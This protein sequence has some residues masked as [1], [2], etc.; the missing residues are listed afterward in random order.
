MNPAAP[1]YGYRRGRH[2]SELAQD[3]RDDAWGKPRSLVVDPSFDWAGDA[4]PRIPWSRTVIYETH[5]KGFTARHPDVPPELRGTYL[6]FAQP[7]VIDYL[8]RLGVTAVEFLPL[9]AFIDDDFLQR[10]GLRNYWGYNSLGFFAPEGRYSS[11][12][13]G[14][15]QVCEFKELVKALHRAGI[16]VIL[17]VVYNHSAEGGNLGPTLSFR[18]IDNAVYYRLFEPNPRFYYDVTGTGNSL[19]TSHPVVRR[20]IV[21]SLRDWVEEMHVDGFRFD[22][23]P[24]LGRDADGRS[25]E[26]GFLDSLRDEPA[27]A[28]AKLIAEPWDLGEFGYR[29]GQFPYGWSEWND[30]FRDAARRF[31]RGEDDFAGELAARMSGSPDIFGVAGRTSLASINF[32]TAHDGFTLRDLVSY[33]R[34][35]NLAN[36]ELNRDGSD[37]NYSYNHGI[38]GETTD[39]AVAAARDRR[40]RNLLATLFLSRGVPML[41]AGD[42]IGRSQQGNN[43]AYCQDNETSWLDWACL[44]CSEPLR[45]F[46]ASLIALRRDNGNLWTESGKEPPGSRQERIEGRHA[47]VAVV[48]PVQDSPPERDDEEPVALPSAF[49][50]W[51]QAPAGSIGEIAELRELFVVLN[52]ER[53]GSSF[54]APRARARDA[55]WEKVLSTVDELAV[56]EERLKPGTV[57]T[58]AA[59]TL[60]VW[61]LNSAAGDG[62][63][64]R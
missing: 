42:E 39:P 30:R 1:V 7:A 60:T 5:L 64:R 23:A 31:W 46:T 56:T 40:V 58:V 57:A 24:A 55:M 20:M 8:K 45:A 9:H 10:R 18:G 36:G 2:V 51:L 25:E 48:L 53:T 61:Q 12:G 44:E 14:G 4:H 6:G 37:H 3:G 21:D 62:P 52:G 35:H 59:N 43:N 54:R 13:D 11:G 50:L 26:A 22:L 15:D 19:D 28:G 63:E 49:A 16:E 33:E 38:E 32:V 17:D 34:K 47:Q 29:L 27:L 41:L